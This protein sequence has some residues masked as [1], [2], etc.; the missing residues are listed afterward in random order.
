MSYFRKIWLQKTNSNLILGFLIYLVSLQ[1]PLFW[2]Q[3][4][5]HLYISPGRFV[6]I[7]HLIPILISVSSSVMPASLPRLTLFCLESVIPCRTNT[8][9]TYT[10]KFNFWIIEAMSLSLQKKSCGEVLFSFRISAAKCMQVLS[11]IRISHMFFSK[12]K[13]CQCKKFL[14]DSD[15]N[16]SIRRKQT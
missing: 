2:Q 11:K 1:L 6:H 5:Q 8:Q 10:R 16:C 15:Q 7:F 12:L 4:I 14:S 3:N 13:H 9:C